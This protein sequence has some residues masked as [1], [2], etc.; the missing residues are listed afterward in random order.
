MCRT[1]VEQ[2]LLH[3]N[4][5]VLMLPTP[6]LKDCPRGTFFLHGFLFVLHIFPWYITGPQYF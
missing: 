2:F 4:R 5:E 6:E 3:E 1:Y